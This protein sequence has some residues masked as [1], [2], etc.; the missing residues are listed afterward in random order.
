MS[1]IDL[2]VPDIGNF[3]A[4]P[5]VDVLVKVGDSVEVETPLITL[6]TDK[7]T[8]DVPSASAGTITEML[9]KRGDKVAKGTLI[10]RVTAAGAAAAAPAATAAPSAQPPPAAPAAA[11]PAAAPGRATAD[12]SGDTVRMPIPD[13]SVLGRVEAQSDRA[14][15]VVVLGSGPGG[16]T[17]AFRAADLGL[18]VTLIERW[19]T[20]GGVCL[21]VGCIPSKTLLHAAKVIDEAAEMSEF[22]LNFSKPTIDVKKLR[23]WKNKVVSKLVNGL[24]VLAKQRKVEVVR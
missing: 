22:G 20:L 6:E 19:A 17:A 21:N 16:Y 11:A 7:A 18:K 3:D 2:V 10:A 15:Q 13:V 24:S 8:M 1:T 12:G 9:V 14:T 23:V 4:V 5:I